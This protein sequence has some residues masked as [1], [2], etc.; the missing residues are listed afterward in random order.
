MLSAGLET[1]TAGT[2]GMPRAAAAWSATRVAGPSSL[3]CANGFNVGPDGALYVAQLYGSCISRVDP[4]T[5]ATTTV[6]P[7]SLDGLIGPDDIAFDTR[8]VMYVSDMSRGAVRAL[9]PKGVTTLVRDDTPAANGITCHGD[10]IFVDECRHGGRLLEL[11]RDGREPR[12]V[13][14]DLNTPNA[15]QVGPDGYI[16]FP[17]VMPGEVWRVPVEGGEAERVLDGL[18]VP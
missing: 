4:D 17:L 14:D 11:F 10:R 12:V 15:L 6:W 9:T 8:G 3:R 1:S 18:A 5:G 16:Y 13:L 7:Q 2:D